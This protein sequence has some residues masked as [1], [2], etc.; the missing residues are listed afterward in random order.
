MTGA[1]TGDRVYKLLDLQREEGV[2]L[3]LATH[4][5]HIAGQMEKQLVLGGP[6][7]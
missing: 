5:R 4:D 7:S 6:S 1:L 3:I 2:G